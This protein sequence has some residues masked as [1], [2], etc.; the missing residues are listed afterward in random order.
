M[1]S[2][3]PFAVL[4]VSKTVALV[5]SS[6]VDIHAGVGKNKTLDAMVDML[7]SIRSSRCETYNTI[8]CFI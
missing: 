4:Y 1:T 3:L 5:N 6:D 2:K 8:G 7:L